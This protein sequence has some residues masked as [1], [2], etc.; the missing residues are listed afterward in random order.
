MIS[1]NVF[2]VLPFVKTVDAIQ[3]LLNHTV[4]KQL[5]GLKFVEVNPLFDVLN[6]CPFLVVVFLGGYFL[7]LLVF[8]YGQVKL[9][10]HRRKD[11]LLTCIWVFLLVSSLFVVVQNFIGFFS[12]LGV[13]L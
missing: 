2:L 6:R 8:R 3:T 9:K 10:D 12:A 11:V 7:G 13:T 4:V 5:T 1:D